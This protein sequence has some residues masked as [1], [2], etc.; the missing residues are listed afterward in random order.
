L[1]VVLFALATT[2]Y[3]LRPAGEVQ[4]ARVIAERKASVGLAAA[5]IGN[6]NQP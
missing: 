5:L 1:S 3:V 2:A 6:A 4:Q